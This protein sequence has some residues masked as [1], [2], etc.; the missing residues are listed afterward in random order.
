MLGWAFGGHLLRLRAE[1]RPATDAAAPCAWAGLAALVVFAVVRGANGYGNL[2]LLREGDSIVQWLHVS[3]YPPSL[4]FSALELGQMALALAALLLAERRLRRPA[5]PRNPFLV[6]GRTALFFYLAHFPLLAVAAVVTGRVGAGGLA[7]TYLAAA[8]VVLV[9][10][11][12]C[13]VYGRYK[14]AHPHGWAQYV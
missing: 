1:G 12:V 6:L 13:L 4:S 14:A 3:K 8:G 5:N 2:G 11:P 10:Y 9:L 7:D